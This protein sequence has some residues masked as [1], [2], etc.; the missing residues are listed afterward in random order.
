MIFSKKLEG[1]LFV[2][3]S[4]IRLFIET[5]LFDLEEKFIGFLFISLF[6]GEFSSLFSKIISFVDWTI[7]QFFYENFMK[8]SQFSYKDCTLSRLCPLCAIALSHHVFR[9]K[10]EKMA[11]FM[12]FIER[13]QRNG[14][15]RIENRLEVRLRFYSRS[16]FHCR[17][18][19][20][21]NLNINLN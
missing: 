6:S 15:F 10:S 3:K 16:G 13:I 17:R 19:D 7:Q 18:K 14:P 2:K 4:S 8:N 20:A 9:Q 5:N 1:T 11:Y 12:R 21:E